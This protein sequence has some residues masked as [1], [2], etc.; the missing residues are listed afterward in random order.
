LTR[1][2]IQ[3]YREAA[4]ASV[5]VRVADTVPDDSERVHPAASPALETYVTC[6]GSGSLMP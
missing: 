6:D 3:K 1:T 4:G 2:R 5:P